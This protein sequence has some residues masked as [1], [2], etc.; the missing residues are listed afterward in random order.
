MITTAS[1]IV[2]TIKA[3]K[4]CVAIMETKDK[5]PRADPEYG[6]LCQAQRHVF[7]A[8]D[9]LKALMVKRP[10]CNDWIMDFPNE[11]ARPSGEKVEA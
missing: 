10:D 4:T 2:L 7:E 9:I 5:V 11:S 1:M 8:V 6:H 3:H